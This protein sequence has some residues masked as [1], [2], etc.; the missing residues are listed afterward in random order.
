MGEIADDMTEGACCSWCGIY[1]ESEHGYPVVCK[2]CWNDA[3][4]EQRKNIQRA[5]KKEL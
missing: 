2:S 1:F 4:P 3:T 5:T